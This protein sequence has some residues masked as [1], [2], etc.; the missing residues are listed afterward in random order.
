[1]RS[2]NHRAVRNE[3]VV[4]MIAMSLF[5]AACGGSSHHSRRTPG[6]AVV[7]G[8]DSIAPPS[9]R[10]AAGLPPMRTTLASERITKVL[11]GGSSWPVEDL[12]LTADGSHLLVTHAERSPGDEQLILWDLRSL[13]KT[14]SD[15]LDSSL[16]TA[17]S[18]DGS[19][20]A[21]ASDGSISVQSLGAAASL[22]NISLPGGRALK[23][24]FSQDDKQLLINTSEE[25]VKVYDFGKHALTSLAIPKSD[26]EYPDSFNDVA[27]APD[28]RTVIATSLGEI[29]T[30]ATGGPPH[31]IHFRCNVGDEPYAVLSADGRTVRCVGR[32]SME[33]W[34]VQTGRLV[35]VVHSR[36]YIIDL[37][38]LPNGNIANIGY[39]NGRI[40]D[41][42]VVEVFS[43]DGTAISH[44]TISATQYGGVISNLS[45]T[46]QWFVIMIAGK[47]GGGNE[48]TGTV[49]ALRK[50]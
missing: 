33:I 40:D 6:N 14:Y 16:E 31:V 18:A 41:G 22:T 45:Y 3:I 42:N 46:A 17:V 12:H 37:Y 36:D 38:D 11:R 9:A 8:N 24:V 10:P 49:L 28:G 26:G 39:A 2:R 43:P 5:V 50:M 19:L 32:T 23:M 29:A 21:T 44:Q 4:S 47:E 15:F 48:V 13:R 20:I 1:M 35:G 34:N 27:F 30:W 7:G 25:D